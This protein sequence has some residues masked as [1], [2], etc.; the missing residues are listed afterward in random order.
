MDRIIKKYYSLVKKF[1]KHD[2]DISEKGIHEKRIIICKVR[3][4]LSAMDIVDTKIRNSKKAFRL[5]GN[6]RN[7]QIQIVIL[8]PS[9]KETGISRYL[10]HL[11]KKLNKSVSKFYMFIK[12][13]K[14]RFPTINRKH[15]TN[16][17]NIKSQIA[18]LHDNLIQ[19]ISLIEVY[20]AAAIHKIRKSFKLFR[21]MI[22]NLSIV[23]SIDKDI[24]DKLKEFQD[25]LGE[26]QDYSMLIKGICEFNRK[27]KNFPIDV[28]QF[29][30]Y[31]NKLISN[32]S[33]EID[34]LL[35]FCNQ[36]RQI[37]TE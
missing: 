10:D 23:I 25:K 9:E 19:N 18:L 30:S 6:I 15:N 29:E 8:Q 36:T 11:D 32:F 31:R 24:L 3:S 17:D 26:I 35:T 7:M 37:T 34:S 5:M 1:Q 22:E 2:K 27:N 12:Q 16:I 21:Y 14:I 20:D 4:I 13:K 33:A 28:F